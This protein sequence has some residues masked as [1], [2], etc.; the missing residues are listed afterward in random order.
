MLLLFFKRNVVFEHV[1]VAVDAHAA[2]ALLAKATQ[3]LC[4]L[5]FFTAHNRCQ[6]VCAP[7]FRVAYNVVCHLIA[8]LLLY[9]YP[10]LRA[11]CHAHA[12]IQ[13]AQIII[14][15]GNGAHRGSRVVT[16]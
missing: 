10:T 12:C 2:K 7:T 16:C 6:H 4:K 3:Q 9:F 13:Q 5:T 11:M 1:H 8:G 14:N 15:F